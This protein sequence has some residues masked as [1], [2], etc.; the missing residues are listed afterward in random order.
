MMLAQ[1]IEFLLYG[2]CA[3]LSHTP[4][5][6]TDKRFKNISGEAFLRGNPSDYK[7]TM[8]QL[9]HIFGDKLLIS[10]PEFDRFCDERNLI[11]H[12]YWRIFHAKIKGGVQ[13][14]DGI[15]FLADFIQRGQDLL[16]VVLGLHAHLIQAGAVMHGR[17]SDFPLTEANQANMKRLTEHAYKNYLRSKKP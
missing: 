1:K 11:A 15:P 8:G 5:A 9:L 12:N 16:N 17:E 2:I 14:D 3:H 7:V 13:R 10:G 6:K 4:E